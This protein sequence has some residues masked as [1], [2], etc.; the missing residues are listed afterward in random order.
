MANLIVLRPCRELVGKVSKYYNGYWYDLDSMPLRMY[1][2]EHE[3]GK[4]RP[5][6]AYET[7]EDGEFAEIWVVVP[8]SEYKDPGT[9]A[10]SGGLG[11]N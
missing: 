4:A 5:T 10:E 8:N 6:G 7:R 3:W 1:P 9:F 2:D 11:D